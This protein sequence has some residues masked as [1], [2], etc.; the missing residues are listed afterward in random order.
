MEFIYL[1][2][3]YTIYGTNVGTITN[4]SHMHD[5]FTELG[6]VK[7]YMTALNAIMMSSQ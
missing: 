7:I 6:Q 3:T 5:G 4:I 1:N 2:T